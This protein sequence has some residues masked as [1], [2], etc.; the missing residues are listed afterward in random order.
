M[1]IF[2]CAG[3]WSL[4]LLVGFGYLQS[5]E[6]TAG[7]VLASPRTLPADVTKSC[8]MGHHKLFMA[9]H[10]RC[11]CTRASVEE[12]SKILARNSTPV[13]VHILFFKPLGSDWAPT[14]LWRQAIAIPGVQAIW[15]EDGIEAARL[16]ALTSGHTLLFNPDGKLLFSGG[17]TSSRGHAGPSDGNRSL[18]SWLTPGET[19]AIEAPVFGCPLTNLHSP[20]TKG[21][22]A[23]QLP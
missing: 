18:A 21:N 17:V 9:A 6:S 10:P 3:L 22:K 5:Y 4:A 15:D 20:C 11:P 2:F 8:P 14:D 1:M 23:C 12:L 16:G 7:A 19:G 13:D